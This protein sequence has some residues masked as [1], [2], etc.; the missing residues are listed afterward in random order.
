MEKILIVDDNKYI[1]YSLTSLLEE[2]GYSITSAADGYK[3]LKEIKTLAPSLV[4]CDIKMPGIDGMEVLRE[5]KK[6][7]KSLPVIMLTAFGEIKNAVDAMKYGAYDY[8]TKPFDN[9]EILMIIKKA[10][11]HKYLNEEVN[12]LRKKFEGTANGKY[13]VGDSEPM[14][15]VIEQVNI[16]APTKLSVLIQGESGTGKEV[17][18][19]LIHSN[20]ERKDKQLVAVDCGAIP[21]NLIESELFGYEKGAF[22]GADTAKEGKFE[23]ANGGT[24]F[25]D[26]ITNLSDAHQIRLLRVIQEKKVTRLGSRKTL[27]IDVRII[28]ATNVKLAD[29]VNNK[30]FRHDLYY[31]LNEF[32][33][34][35]PPLRHRKEDIPQFV[36]YFIKN[37]NEELNK[38]IKSVSQQVMDEITEY[39]WPGNV[40]ELRN[41]VRRAVLMTPENEDI[42]TIYIADEIHNNNGDPSRQDDG[43]SSLKD[44]KL[45]LE[46]DMIIK[47]LKESGGNRANAAKLLNMSER[48]FYRKIK[49]LGL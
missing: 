17:I 5:I 18:A 1:R 33:I 37:A 49:T 28:V 19:T 10:L 42:K 43:L 45:E 41:V 39:S 2:E 35:L 40:R 14:K 8:V 24:L 6:I 16:V 7:N 13:I 47:S 44:S 11:E 31:R 12:L 15:R 21:E 9:D 22:T 32:N 48:T 3:A 46:K 4:I 34:D 27:D 23:Q 25:L 29:A 20:S 26:E 30:K 36:S 38:G